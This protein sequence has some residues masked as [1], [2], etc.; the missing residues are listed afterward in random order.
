MNQ[1]IKNQV[2]TKVKVI[3]NWD[4]NRVEY[5]DVKTVPSEENVEVQVKNAVEKKYGI[6]D[7]KEFV[8]LD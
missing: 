7:V 8:I 2:M 6:Y 1:N 4:N 5:M 3:M